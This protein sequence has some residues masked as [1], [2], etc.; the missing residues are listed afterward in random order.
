VAKAQLENWDRRRF[1][2]EAVPTIPMWVRSKLTVDAYLLEETSQNFI[3]RMMT[4]RPDLFYDGGKGPCTAFAIG[5]L[6]RV[7]RETYRNE[8]ISQHEEL[9]T[10]CEDS[11][12]G[13]VDTIMEDREALEKNQRIFGIIKQLM[14]ELPADKRDAVIQKYCGDSVLELPSDVS[15]NA[16][17][18]RRSRGL[19]IIRKEAQRL[20]LSLAEANISR[21][22]ARRSP[23]K[24]RARASPLRRNRL[25]NQL[26]KTTICG[27][28]TEGQVEEIEMSVNQKAVE[29]SNARAL[30]VLFDSLPES[31]KER[32]EVLATVRE[33]FEREFARRSRCHS[34]SV[35]PSS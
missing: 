20:G 30:Q 1:V 21:R 7:Y 35:E 8:G 31:L 15:K 3:L 23:R 26:R 19:Q 14:E 29:A 25:P 9:V 6:W 18:V 33:I 13:S 12:Y 5:I 2:Q 28:F 34:D 10:D 11:R 17:C 16:I 4:R 24:P 27:T 22:R 32:I